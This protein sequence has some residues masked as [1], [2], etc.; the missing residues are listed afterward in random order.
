MQNPE[1]HAHDVY[2]RTLST[3]EE[4]TAQKDF[5]IDVVKAEYQALTTYQG[6]GWVGRNAYKDAEIEGQ[7]DAY[8][9]FLYRYGNLKVDK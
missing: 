7:I 6:H 5:D 3:L 4:R 2:Q 1:E 8:Q 9:V